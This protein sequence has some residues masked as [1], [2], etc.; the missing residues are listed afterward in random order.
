MNRDELLALADRVE[1]L[2]GPDREVDAAIA[3]AALG[4]FTIP[5]RYEGDKVGYGYIDADGVRVH[6]GHGG[7]QMVPRLTA[8]LD[9]AMTLYTVL[10]DL[11]STCPL[12]ATAA[13]LRALAA[14][15]D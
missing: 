1:A 8:S 13:A 5:P 15:R 2:T 7:D 12:K 11:T 9:A 10:P 4:W 3:V 6:P 14:Q